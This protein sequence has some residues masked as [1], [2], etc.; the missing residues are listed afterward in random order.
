MALAQQSLS[1]DLYKEMLRIRLI[2]EA[3]A[4]RYHEQKMRCP[5][6]LSIGQEAVAVGV[7]KATL[8]TD[9]LISGHRAHAHYLAKGGSLKAMIAEIYGKS[10]GCCRG[11]GGSMHLVDL[12]VGIYGSTPIVGGSIPVGVGLAFATM[13]RQEKN[14]TLI[15]FGEGSTEEGVFSE[16]LN[17]AALKNLPVLFV[18]ENNFYSVYSPL[19]VRQSDRR[20]RAAIARAHGITAKTGNGNDVEEVRRL[21]EEAVT[22]IR[23]GN[24]PVFLE[25]DT[26]RHREHC[27]PNFDNDIGYRTEEEFLFWE[28]K[29]P[30]KLQ[31]QKISSDFSSTND[32]ESLSLPILSEIEEAFAFAEESPFPEFDI[33][34]ES[35][36]V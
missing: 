10:T 9:Y 30:L 11:R 34:K 22:S 21:A 3:I 35:P 19:H 7:C 36:Y 1:L 12:S 8:P 16:S 29:C 2:E 26:Y 4:G 28:R 13:L 32:L 24:G 14:I 27:G 18:C 23:E 33:D 31:A 15:F 25:F 6:H 17:F 5:V 20:D